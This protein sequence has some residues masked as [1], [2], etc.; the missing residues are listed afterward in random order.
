MKAFLK[1]LV[2]AIK[3]F[4]KIFK[5]EKK[6]DVAVQ[7]VVVPIEPVVVAAAPPPIVSE[8][9][10]VTQVEKPQ[11]EKPKE[12]VTQPSKPDIPQPKT[13]VRKL[14]CNCFIKGKDGSGGFVNNPNSSRKT[15]KVI[16]PSKYTEKIVEVVA[17]TEDGT[18]LERLYNKQ[19][20]EWGNRER[21]YG[22]KNIKDYPKNLIVGARLNDDSVVCVLIPNPQ[23]RQ[24]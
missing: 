7:Q 20:C 6:E 18:F 13:P 23:V 21:Y 3:S 5:E 4:I 22:K 11:E 16:F 1:K 10:P 12:E 15:L 17:W 24:D 14:N 19:P 8:P 9:T 2:L